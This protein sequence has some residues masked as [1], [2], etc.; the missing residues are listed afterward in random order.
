MPHKQINKQIEKKNFFFLSFG[1]FNVYILWFLTFFQK[2]SD[3]FFIHIKKF[4]STF[5]F[6]LA[7][8]GLAWLG[9]DYGN[10][11]NTHVHKTSLCVCVCLKILVH[12]FRVKKIFF[13]TRN[14]VFSF[15]YVSFMGMFSI[16]ILFFFVLFS[17]FILYFSS[18]QFIL[19]HFFG[20]KKR[21]RKKT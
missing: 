20:H 6:G 16:K 15:S 10:L 17:S 13:F 5:R 3:F 8:L 2:F 9:Y 19:F 18:F 14:I 7:W 4:R 1:L 12:F 21:K 11:G